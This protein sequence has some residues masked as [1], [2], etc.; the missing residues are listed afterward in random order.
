MVIEVSGICGR[1]AAG[2]TPAVRLRVT[3]VGFRLNTRLECTNDTVDSIAIE[4]LQPIA[5]AVPAERYSEK[6]RSRRL[7]NAPELADG[8][9]ICFGIVFGFG[10]IT[11]VKPGVVESYVVNRGKTRNKIETVV[12]KGCS[13]QIAKYIRNLPAPK[14]F[15]LGGQRHDGEV[16]LPQLAMTQNEAMIQR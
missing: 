1:S 4:Y 14:T 11:G 7:E 3:K 8:C 2:K 15:S 9:Q 12:A 13:S 10:A 6:K 16:L 5:D